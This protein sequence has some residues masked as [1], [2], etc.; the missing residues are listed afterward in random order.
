MSILDIFRMKGNSV[1][2]NWHSF[3]TGTRL[4][5]HITVERAQT[6]IKY[7]G[8]GFSLPQESELKGI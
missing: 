5:R 8:T 4:K 7:N 1:C 2:G 6:I 3:R